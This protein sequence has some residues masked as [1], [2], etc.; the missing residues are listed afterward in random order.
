MSARCLD[1]CGGR[2]AMIVPTPT[3]L[4]KA[5]TVSRGFNVRV[6]LASTVSK[7]QRGLTY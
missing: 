2:S 4:R 3:S 6:P 7:R 1:L 5:S